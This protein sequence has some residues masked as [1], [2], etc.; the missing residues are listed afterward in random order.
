MN[1][2]GAPA[3][4]NDDLIGKIVADRYRVVRKLGQGG[5]GTVYLAV[6]E[7]L[8]K[9]VAIKVLDVRTGN[10]KEIEA[11]F[12]REAI[13]SANLRHPNIAEA[14]DFGRLP[15]GSLYLVMEYIE[16]K[17]AKALLKA[18]PAGLPALRVLRILR[19]VAAALARAHAQDVVHRDLKPENII[20]FDREDERDAV[21]VIDFGIAK[22]RSAVLGAEG[23]SITVAGAVF[24]TPAYMAPEQ[25]RGQIADA[26]ADQY[27]FGVTAFELLT[28]RVPYADADVSRLLMKHI[29]APIPSVR[30]SAPHLPP[31]AN[32]VFAKLLGKQPEERYPTIEQA[33]AA[34]ES[35][36][37]GS[38]VAGTMPPSGGTVIMGASSLGPIAAPAPAVPVRAGELPAINVDAPTMAA[39]A[40]GQATQAPMVTSVQPQSAA[41]SARAGSNPP[42]LMIAVIGSFLVAVCIAVVFFVVRLPGSAED[43]R[44]SADDETSR[45][46][47][48]SGSSRTGATSSN[49]SKPSS[50]A[51]PSSTRRPVPISKYRLLL[52]D[53][54]YPF[55]V[56]SK[57]RHAYPVRTDDE[58]VKVCSDTPE[59]PI[60]I[61]GLKPYDPAESQWE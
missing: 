50:T 54:K 17:T 31:A 60:P 42:F 44:E 22:I 23:K 43:A 26:R 48:P 59:G 51:G 56:T 18:S 24:G 57:L 46:D 19:Q 21:K 36:L 37:S 7:K 58:G 4:A 5:M 27:A 49:T 20:V 32:E 47:K 53:G 38:F 3:S 34:L 39:P 12:R 45:E 52:K 9:Q 41:T 33:F 29:S 35:A 13:A 2:R 25:V 28:G 40:P 30:E 15:D 1:D 16:G 8:R 6:H 14:T 10:D 55:C 11:R 61:D